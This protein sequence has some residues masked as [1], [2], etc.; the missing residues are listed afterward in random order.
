MT[1]K[2]GSGTKSKLW[3]TLVVIMTKLDFKKSVPKYP[4]DWTWEEIQNIIFFGRWDNKMHGKLLGSMKFTALQLSDYIGNK[5]KKE[6][7]NKSSLL[8]WNLGHKWTSQN[9][10]RKGKLDKET[11]GKGKWNWQPK[12]VDDS[13]E[14]DQSMHKVK[15]FLNWEEW[16]KP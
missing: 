11:N 4:K 6:K 12:T 16:T 1:Y 14:N 5:I 7:H 10:I 2:N 13:F 8:S 15:R 9:K 3:P